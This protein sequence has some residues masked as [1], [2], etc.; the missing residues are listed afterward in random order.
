MPQPIEKSVISQSDRT[1]QNFI[2]LTT[3][4]ATRRKCKRR[5]K[6]KQK[7]KNKKKQK[8]LAEQIWNR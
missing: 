4:Q 1:E 3:S 5:G 7:K 6:K 8:K 2:N